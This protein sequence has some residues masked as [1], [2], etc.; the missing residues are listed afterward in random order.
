[1]K[2]TVC[3]A[4]KTIIIIFYNTHA[5]IYIYIYVCVYTY[6]MYIFHTSTDRKFEIMETIS[7]SSTSRF[8][9]SGTT[10]GLSGYLY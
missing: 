2:K 6:N 5:C 3:A 9:T 4:R 1:M 8:F 7:Q 10:S